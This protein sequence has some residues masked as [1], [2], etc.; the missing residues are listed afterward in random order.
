[1]TNPVNTL[2]HPPPDSPEE[3]AALASVAAALRRN[4]LYNALAASPE[5]TEQ[6]DP[7]STLPTDAMRRR[8]LTAGPLRGARKIMMSK[9]FLHE[10]G[11]E[12]TALYCLGTAL[13]GF[14][15]VVHGGV[16]VTVMDEAMGRLASRILGVPAV[17][18]RLSVDYKAPTLASRGEAGGG[19]LW[20]VVGKDA[21]FV[22]L[23]AEVEE[24]GER[25]AVVR[26]RLED[27]NGKL[28]V[29]G[30]AVFVVPK[31]WNPRP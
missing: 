31:K 5:W 13:C 12:V 21:E 10:S 11:R 22:V 6:E 19:S 3:A 23:K 27:G 14:P 4:P 15:N 17:T 9:T 8:Q 16:L 7:S 29:R 18:A 20:P 26:G 1:M 30:N 2:P 28:L 25:K 24:L